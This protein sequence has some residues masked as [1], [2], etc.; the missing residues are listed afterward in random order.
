MSLP[1]AL[2]LL[3]LCLFGAIALAAL[4]KDKGDAPSSAILLE[5]PTELVFSQAEEKKAE[6]ME[7]SFSTEEISEETKQV[8]NEE[9]PYANRIDEFFNLGDY[10][11]PIVETIS[12]SSRVDWLK[13]RPAWVADYASHFRTSRHF[14]ARSLNGNTDYFRQNVSNGDRFNVLRDDKDF[15]FHLL[16]DL[17][18]AKMWFYFIDDETSEVT[19]VKVYD[20]GLGRLNEGKI[21]GSLTPIGQYSLGDRIAIYKPKMMGQ[22]NNERVE[23]MRV[24]GTRWIPFD[25]EIKGTTAPAKGFGLHGAPWNYNEATNQL[26]ED[27][28]TIGKNE[29]DGCIRLK[30]EDIEELFAIIISRSTIVEI[31]KDFYDAELSGNRAKI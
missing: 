25:R 31:V 1:R 10:K 27:R 7:E 21:S 26:E 9:L 3:V 24:F 15:H 20:V 16:I 28:D 30:S 12:Y 4:R 11:F 18:R 23:M 22:F 5:A 14:I 2:L 6:I 19:L 8:R 29:S 17:S 13:G